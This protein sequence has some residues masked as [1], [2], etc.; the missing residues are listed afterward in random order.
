MLEIHYNLVT[1]SAVN[2]RWKHKLSGD[3]SMLLIHYVVCV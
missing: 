2:L 3:F 1:D